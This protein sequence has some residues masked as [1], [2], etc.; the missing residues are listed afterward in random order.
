LSSHLLYKEKVITVIKENGLLVIAP[1]VN[2]VK[3]V[4]KEVHG[5]IR[6]GTLLCGVY[7]VL[8][9]GFA[10]KGL[11]VIFFGVGG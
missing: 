4:L 10:A 1:V 7:P 9:S 8:K 3:F 11:H 6:V 2:V 5:F